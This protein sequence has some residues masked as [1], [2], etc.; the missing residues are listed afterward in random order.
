MSMIN[1]MKNFFMPQDDYDEEEEYEE[2]EQRVEP[3]QRQRTSTPAAMPSKVVP[4]NAS[5]NH[6]KMEILNFTMKNY[7]MTGE[8]CSYI[9]SR[10]PVIVNMQQ[11]TPGEV[12]RAVDYLTG[13]CYA[14]SGSVERIADNIFVFAPEDINISPENIKQ[15]NIWP[16]A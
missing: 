9:K 16:N 10:K 14:L 7:E 15:K 3:I 13:A 4:L 1:K 2:V 11:L 8:I 6:N 12:Q 5:Q